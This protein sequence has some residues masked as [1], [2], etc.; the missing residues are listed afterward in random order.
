MTVRMDGHLPRTARNF[1]TLTPSPINTLALLFSHR[2]RISSSDNKVVAGARIIPPRM[3]AIAISH[4]HDSVSG[5]RFT[6]LKGAFLPCRYSWKN[7]DHRL[8]R[9]DSQALK[10]GTNSMGLAGEVFEGHGAS[11]RLVLRNPI[12]C[13][14]VVRFGRP[15]VDDIDG[16]IKLLRSL[17]N[18]SMRMS[19]D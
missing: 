11:G 5:E 15:V 4:L 2:Y 17:D 7:Y 3:A 13:L 19:H 8:A 16:E 9:F 18:V 1:S 10:Q 14:H 6:A 12:H